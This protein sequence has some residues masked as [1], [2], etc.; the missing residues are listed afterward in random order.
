VP[1]SQIIEESREYKILDED[2]NLHR[3][4]KLVFSI[5]GSDVPFEYYG[6]MGTT[7]TDPPILDNPSETREVGG[8]EYELFFDG[9]RL[10]MVAWH[11][12]KAAYWLSNT[13]T[14]TLEE[15]EMLAI[16]DSMDEVAPPKQKKKK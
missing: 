16:A 1:G 5:P 4:Y 9:D 3:A 13:L 6:L 7:W 10:R 12:D 2:K 11:T 15:D 14:Q 8:R